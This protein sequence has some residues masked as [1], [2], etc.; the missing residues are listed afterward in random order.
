MYIYNLSLSLYIYIHIRIY[1]YIY[2][3]IVGRSG[4]SGARGAAAGRP[5][6]GPP[7]PPLLGCGV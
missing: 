3:Y 5:A 2:I 4:L 1:I 7:P 6:L